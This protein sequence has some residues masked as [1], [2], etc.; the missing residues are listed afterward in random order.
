[1]PEEI[2]VTGMVL[3]AAPSMEYDR[4]IVLLSREKGK[5]TAFAHGA[6][7][8]TSRFLAATAPLSFGRF[9][10]YAGRTAYTLRETEITNY[11][12]E[13]KKDFRGMCYGSYFLEAADYFSG[14]NLD[15]TDLLHLLYVSLLA[16]SDPRLENEL[17]RSIFEMKA[18]LIDGVYPYEA[19]EDPSLRESTRYALSYVMQAPIRRLYSFTLKPEIL[20]EFRSVQERMMK[21]YVGHEFRSM[22]IIRSLLQGGL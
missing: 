15:A 22:G 13:L 16:L 10:L 17:V 11:F 2:K 8:P 1:M 19:A 6:R 5:I 20:D 14:E 18:M 7:K 9:T 12:R 3:S 4:R 21:E